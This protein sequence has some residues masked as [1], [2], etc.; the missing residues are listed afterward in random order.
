MKFSHKKTLNGSKIKLNTKNI[1]FNSKSKKNEK[2]KKFIDEEMNG[3]SYKSALQYDK[4]NYFQYYISLI[5]T[6][7]NLLCALCNK[8]DYNCG[9]IKINLFFI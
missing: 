5:K 7:H 6:Q 9:I 3:F 4:R 1:N 2:I 8:N